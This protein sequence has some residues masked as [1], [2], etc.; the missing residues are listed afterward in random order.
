MNMERDSKGRFLPGQT[1]NPKGR[2]K[3]TP[4]AEDII[5]AVLPEVITRLLDL[6]HSENEAIALQAAIALRDWKSAT[7]KNFF[8]IDT[9]IIKGVTYHLKGWGNQEQ[10]YL[11]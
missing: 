3:D 2:P 7:G 9:D 10:P 6:M 4:P 5:E 8:A 1:G 11:L